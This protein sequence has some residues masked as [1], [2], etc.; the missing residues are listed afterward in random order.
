LAAVAGR[1]LD[2]N[3]IRRIDPVIDL[4]VWL[5]VCAEAGLLELEDGQWR[6]AHDKL[7][8]GILN[9]LAPDQLPKLH[10]M[11]AEATEAVHPGD[12]SYAYELVDHWHIAHEVDKEII[13]TRL[14]VNQRLA[15]SDYQA[16]LSLLQQVM[17]VVS[18]QPLDPR[19]AELRVLLAETLYSIGSYEEAQVLLEELLPLARQIQDQ[20]DV[21]AAARLLGNIHMAQGKYEEARQLMQESLTI[22]QASGDQPSI[23]QA[24]RTLGVI[25][26]NLGDLSAAIHFYQQSLDL[27]KSLND[28]LGS[29]GAL[30]N[31]A[32]IAFTQGLY[33]E[34]QQLNEQ[35]LAQFTQVGFRWGVAY[36]LI[37]LGEVA[38]NAHEYELSKQRLDDAIV[39]CREI[40]HRWGT[41]FALTYLGRTYHATGQ[42]DLAELCFRSAL[43]IAH[44]LKVWPLALE[45]LFEVALLL[46][47]NQQWTRAA[48][49]LGGIKE[50]P[51]MELETRRRLDTVLTTLEAAPDPLSVKANL[52]AGRALSLEVLIEQ[53]LA[54][55][56]WYMLPRSNI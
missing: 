4:N 19:V 10:R 15:S 21:A 32:S 3:I 53:V 54:L 29:A 39:I 49:V 55:H 34:A 46:I 18:D 48:W 28:Q 41:A 56:H 14:A 27:F 17:A 30:A 9:G 50:H 8:D 11:V 33:A 42:I 31:L 44:E 37:R 16:A 12:M 2:L 23:A 51:A 24:L 38:F 25:A 52:A 35:A 26:E 45:A 36:T 6:F 22:A 40:G 47:A 13:Y 43:Q 20:R 7:R 5:L 1:Q